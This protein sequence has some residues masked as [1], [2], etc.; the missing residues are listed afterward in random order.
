[1]AI[2]REYPLSAFA[3]RMPVV[4][5]VFICCA[6]F[7]ERSLS[8]PMELPPDRVRTALVV[9]NENMDNEKSIEALQAHFRDRY[10]SVR[11]KVDNPIKTADA[12]Y[13][14]LMKHVASATQIVVDITAFT[15]E[16][17]LILLA[18]LRAILLDFD[19]HVT[20]VYSGADAYMLGGKE[21]L[22]AG[23]EDVRTVLGYPGAMIPSQSVHLVILVGFELERALR[24]VDEYE[25]A[26]VSLGYSLPNDSVSDKLGN[27]NRDFH[28]RLA[29]TLGRVR[30][31][32][33]SSCDAISTQHAIIDQVKLFPGYSSVVAPLNT[34]VSTVGCAL[35]AWQDPS[36]Q[37]CYAEAK[38]YNTKGYSRPGNSFYVVEFKSKE[39]L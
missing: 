23:V 1:M 11:T 20:L 16:Q 6:S 12:L 18:L 28:R 5:D 36:L 24:I 29:A 32:T 39:G 17:L 35:A 19:R 15:H 30:E 27:R 31:F 10:C 37:L 9:S 14:E 22:S 34:K 7:E 3:E 26:Q 33:F 38:H 8:I 13:G 4:I 21:W 2:C 25:P